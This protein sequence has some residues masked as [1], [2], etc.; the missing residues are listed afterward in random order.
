[1]ANN[2]DSGR[3]RFTAG[4]GSV[5]SYQVSGVPWIT[6][7]V[8]GLASGGEDKLIFPSVAKTVTVINTDVGSADIH[9]HFNSKT[10][11]DVSGGLHYVAL[12]ALNDAFTFGCKCKEIYISSPTW[13]GGPASYTVVAELTGIN[14]SEMFVLTGS[15][16]TTINGT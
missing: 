4:I 3:N 5:G 13:G 10:N 16:L 8:E 15:G 12:N 9:V 2:S 14:T 6:G 1:M 11:T 7:S